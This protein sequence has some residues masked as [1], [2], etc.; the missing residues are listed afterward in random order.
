MQF[1]YS[2]QQIACIHC[3][4]YCNCNAALIELLC[5][6]KQV[7]GTVANLVS[8]DLSYIYFSWTRSSDLLRITPFNRD[9]F[10]KKNTFYTEVIQV[11]SS[12]WSLRKWKEILAVN[13]MKVSTGP[14]DDIS[15]LQ[16]GARIK[17][18]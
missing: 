17:T 8:R 9:L 12:P 10:Q 4:G 3:T 7:L 2:T 18:R 11:R 13:E 16:S 15:V 14:A 5:N 1:I 6:P